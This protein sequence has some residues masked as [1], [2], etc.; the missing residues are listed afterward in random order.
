MAR[1]RPCSDVQPMSEHPCRLLQPLQHRCLHGKVP[2]DGG[3][4]GPGTTL[5]TRLMRRRCGGHVQSSTFAC[6]WAEALRWSPLIT[7]AQVQKYWHQLLSLIQVRSKRSCRERTAVQLA[8]WCPRRLFPAAVP[9]CDWCPRCRRASWTPHLSSPTTCRC[10]T[11][12]TPT[13]CSTTRRRGAS[14]LC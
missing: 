8:V 6:L 2:V 11:R 12:P 3:G 9:P 5:C 13:R 10:L 1:V 7:T 4:A 14:K